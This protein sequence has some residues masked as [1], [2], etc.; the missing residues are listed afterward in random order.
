MPNATD[1]KSIDRSTQLLTIAIVAPCYDEAEVLPISIPRLA[2]VI[3][4]LVEYHNCSASSYIVL[5]DDG[6][7]DTTW[8][9]ISAAVTRFP[10][11]VH[12]IRLSRN[13]GHQNAL[14]AGLSYF[15]GRCDAAISIDVDLQDDLEAL[16]LM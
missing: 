1:Q 5:V 3:S 10:G 2:S 9:H 6:S 12:G 13:A 8:D 15:T 4:N 7:K 14:M 11:I 16:P